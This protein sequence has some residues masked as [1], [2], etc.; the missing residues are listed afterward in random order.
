MRSATSTLKKITRAVIFISLVVM[1]FIFLSKSF[2]VSGDSSEDGM[3]SRISNAYRGEAENTLDVIF[4]GNSDVYRG[5]SPVDLYHDTGITSAVAGRPNNTLKEISSDI[6]DILKYQKPKV[7]ALETDCMFSGTNSH[8][9]KHTAETTTIFTKIKKAAGDADS[10]IISAINYY[11]PLVKY[12]DR[13]KKLTLSS[14][15]DRNRGFYKFKNKGMA[16]SEKV[17]PYTAGNSYMDPSEGKSATLNDENRRFFDEIAEKCR[18]NDIRLVLL[19]VPSANTWNDA[20]SQAV[21][22]LAAQRGLIY[23]DYNKTFPPGF[24]W[25]LHTT[26]GGNH[27]NYAGAVTVTRDFGL[28]LRSDLKLPESS[29]T[30]QQKEEWQQDYRDFH[31]DVSKI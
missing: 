2:A 3:E 15:I 31:S 18:D 24:D 23:Y 20:K 12:H 22:Q 7:I 11:F 1:T 19:T 29:L 25:T 26:D 4:V 28:K 5:V 27:L 13:W 10:A 9:K 21:A 17:S 14:F 30:D 16:Y 6:D 8:F